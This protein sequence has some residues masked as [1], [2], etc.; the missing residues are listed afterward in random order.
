ML[1]R[2]LC[3]AGLRDHIVSFF[4]WGGEDSLPTNNPSTKTIPASFPSISYNVLPLHHCC[5]RC[6]GI[7]VLLE[8]VPHSLRRT[9]PG[10]VLQECWWRL[11]RLYHSFFREASLWMPVHAA[12]M[13]RSMCKLGVRPWVA[14]RTAIVQAQCKLVCTL[15]VW[16]DVWLVFDQA[17]VFILLAEL[18]ICSLQVISRSVWDMQVRAHTV[19]VRLALNAHKQ[20]KLGRFG[21][22]SGSADG[23]AEH[24]IPAADGLHQAFVNQPLST[25]LL[26][27]SIL[28]PSPGR[29]Q[30]L[31]YIYIYKYT[32]SISTLQVDIII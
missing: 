30:P 25:Q 22:D 8:R 28:Y 26:L 16:S 5:H 29:A 24:R 1:C 20:F 19:V 4:F 2:D 23:C 31:I 17:T 9:L 11:C 13:L 15:P 3:A 12:S 7:F 18:S 27:L 21:S 6:A 32:I 10:L 14:C